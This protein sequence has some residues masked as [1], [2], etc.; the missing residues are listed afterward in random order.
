MDENKLNLLKVINYEMVRCCGICVHGEFNNRHSDFG[1]C[2]VNTYR[3]KKHSGDKRYLS[4]NRF[5]KCNTDEFE[6][7]EA[8][9]TT[10]GDF[11]KFLSK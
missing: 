2:Q 1:T 5:G 6:L 9:L 4:I 10:Y 8:K 11:A 7:D 3:H